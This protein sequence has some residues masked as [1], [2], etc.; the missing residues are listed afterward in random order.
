MQ[1]KEVQQQFAG[2]ADVLER[3][4]LEILEG[5]GLTET[6]PIVAWSVPW[7]K[8]KGTVGLPLPGVENRIVNE[9]GGT[10][11]ANEEGEILIK[12]PN[13]MAGYHKLP[14]Q[15]AEVIDGDAYFHTG[16]WGR[17]DDAGMLSITGRKKEM[18]IIGG[19]NVFPREIE[20]V[21]NRHPA[22]RD[23]AVVGKLDPVRGELPV[24]FVELNEDA[25]FDESAIRAFC[26]DQLA[27]FKVPREVRV[28][29]QLPRNATGKVLRRELKP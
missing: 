23:S 21:L 19:E 10:L 6:S 29:E 3:F 16:D 14:Q 7:S 13:V 4:D 20:E 11:A 26:R 9:H 12:G 28:M 1:R 24:A 27:Q 8:G 2:L 15:T 17:I 18:L 25:G 22:V 5:Y